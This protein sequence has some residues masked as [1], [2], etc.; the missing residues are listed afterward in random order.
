MAGNANISKRR[1]RN[2]KKRDRRLG[3]I[4]YDENGKMIDDRN[5]QEGKNLGFKDIVRENALFEKYYRAQNF[6]SD[7]DFDKMLEVFKT[8]LPAS[9]RITGTRAQSAALLKII[10]GRYFAELTEMLASGEDVVV[11]THLPWYPDKLA[12]QLN[13]TRKDIRRQERYHRLHGFL[14]AETE[15]ESISRQD[16][17]SM[18]PPLVLDVKPHHTVLDMCAAP[19]SKVICFSFTFMYGSL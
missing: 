13:V 18:L 11:P 6:C 1:N 4:K 16:T 15:S 9:F 19:G 10:E 17:V 2:R 7:E 8:D 3:K 5:T 12:W 14:V